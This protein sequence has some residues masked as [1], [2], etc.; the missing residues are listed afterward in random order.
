MLAGFIGVGVACSSS[1][2]NSGP[3]P[4]DGAVDAGN[5]DGRIDSGTEDA[6]VDAGDPEDAEVR[7]PVACGNMT[8]GADEYCEVECT[9]CGTDA[10]LPASSTVECRPIPDACTGALCDCPEVSQRGLCDSSTRTLNIPC[11]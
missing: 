10:G 4:A 6:D 2:T 5:R 3:G 8:C 1:R 7:G 11:A 9:C